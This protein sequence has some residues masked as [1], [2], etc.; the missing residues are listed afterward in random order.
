MENGII[1]YEGASPLD[2]KPIVGIALP[3][4]KTGN[5]KTGRMASTLIIRSD[6]DPITAS[7]LGEDYSICGDCMH[8]G[9]A[10]PNKTSG[11]ADERSCYVM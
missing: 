1:F 7:R 11:G 2:G 6:I 9:I 5:S 3:D 4:K 10:N 8:R